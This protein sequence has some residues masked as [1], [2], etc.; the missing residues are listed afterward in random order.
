MRYN[1]A[2]NVA[3]LVIQSILAAILI[4]L[5]LVQSKGKGFSRSFSG[6]SSFTRRGLERVVYKA[7]FF[8]VAVFILVS[9]AQ[10]AV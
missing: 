4:L 2:V 9:L 6:P 1:E 10:L 8:L 5:I 3:L 7:T